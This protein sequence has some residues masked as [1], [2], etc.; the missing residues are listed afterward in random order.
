[1][2]EPSPPNIYYSSHK[3]LSARKPNV[4]IFYLISRILTFN[5]EQE[6]Q[7]NSSEKILE[8]VHQCSRRD[9][10]PHPSNMDKILS[11]A[12][13]PI[14]PRLLKYLA[15]SDIFATPH[16]QQKIL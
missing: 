15:D 3:K 10:N 8:T 13:L 4:H 2:L 12:C 11:L 6:Q 5:R 14:P 7:K 16:Q 9:L 1:M